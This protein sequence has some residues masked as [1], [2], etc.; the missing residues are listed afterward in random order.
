M[1]ANSNGDFHGANGTMT[2]S[3]GANPSSV[4]A[5]HERTP[6]DSIM[7]QQYGQVTSHELNRRLGYNLMANSV[8]RSQPMHNTFPQSGYMGANNNGNNNTNNPNNQR[9][10]NCTPN[11]SLNQCTS[12]NGQMANAMNGSMQCGPMIHG[13]SNG[14]MG[15]NGNISHQ[16]MNCPPG[17]KN[18]M[19]MNPSM[20]MMNNSGMYA[21]NASSV[22]MRPGGYSA[23]NVNNNPVQQFPPQPQVNPSKRAT[24][25]YPMNNGNVSYN[26]SIPGTVGMQPTYG[27]NQNNFNNNHVSL[28]CCMNFVY[29]LYSIDLYGL[30]IAF[31]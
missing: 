30:I 29:R 7:N 22:R 4:M 1:N 10:T 3:V 8:V 13:P 19:S 25:Q 18:N 5:M 27:Q 24:H 15:N 31:F 16:D 11:G 23:S 26:D 21:S 12:I 9:V 20:S 17:M 2:P 14:M 28:D 6:S